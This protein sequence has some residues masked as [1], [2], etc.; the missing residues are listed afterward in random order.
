MWE[1]ITDWLNNLPDWAQGLIKGLLTAI[2]VVAA[3]AL[4]IVLIKPILLT[5]AVV[6]GGAALAVLGGSLYGLIVGGEN[7]NFLHAV[8]ASAGGFLAP[9]VGKLAGMVLMSSPVLALGSQ[10]ALLQAKIGS[11]LGGAAA[12]IKGAGGIFGAL[13]LGASNLG[14]AISGWLSTAWAALKGSKVGGWITSMGTTISGWLSTAWTAFKGTTFGKAAIAF[15][16]SKFFIGLALPSVMTSIFGEI[17]NLLNGGSMSLTNFLTN[18][19]FGIATGGFLR[20]AY[21]IFKSTGFLGKMA[22]WL[23]SSVTLGTVYTALSDNLSLTTFIAST[24]ISGGLLATYPLVTTLGPVLS[25]LY[26]TTENVV[27]DKIMPTVKENINN[28]IDWMKDQYKTFRE[29]TIKFWIEKY[30]R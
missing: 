24:L 7:F 16:K 4:V 29:N 21:V 8:L 6:I 22:T 26:N 20:N 19:V 12:W 5:S 30:F 15:V 13:R 10:Y 14:G 11:V 3:V 25:S 17:I 18:T 1:G 23:G 9:V 27:K 2:A 28:G